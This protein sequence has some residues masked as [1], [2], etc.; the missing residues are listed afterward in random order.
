MGLRL[1]VT[2]DREVYAPEDP[3]AAVLTLRND[4]AV[5]VQLTFATAQ[6]Y[7][8]EVRDPRDSVVRRWSDGMMFGQMLG[9]EWIAGGDR[10]VLAE[11][12]PA[13]SRSGWY[14]V[15]GRISAME[16]TLEGRT[17]IR[18]RL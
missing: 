11:R 2:T 12:L 7:D 10:L 17:R 4:A 5:A 16:Q 15:V 1:I 18:V 3:I 8:L 9:E 14:D 13:P 6:R